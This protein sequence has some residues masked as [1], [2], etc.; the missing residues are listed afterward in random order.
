MFCSPAICLLVQTQQQQRF[1]RLLH[2]SVLPIA[3]NQRRTNLRFP[4]GPEIATIKY[5]LNVILK[6]QPFKA[7][8]S[9]FQVVLQTRSKPTRN[10][11]ASP[12]RQMNDSKILCLALILQSLFHRVSQYFTAMFWKYVQWCFQTLV[13]LFF[14][15]SSSYWYY[16][17]IQEQ[18]PDQLH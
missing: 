4:A 12:H 5:T 9:F 10:I 7:K 16:T 3:S 8:I 17:F 1:C 2:R 18:N 13:S 14:F 6:F 15:L 11:P